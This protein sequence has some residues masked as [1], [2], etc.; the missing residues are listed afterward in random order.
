MMIPPLV[1]RK[2][3]YQVPTARNQLEFGQEA[4]MIAK[5]RSNNKIHKELHSASLKPRLPG[6]SQKHQAQNSSAGP[7]LIQWF[8]DV[9]LEGS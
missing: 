7:D 8:L 6:K 5:R 2:P 1:D 4:H 3:Y 9:L